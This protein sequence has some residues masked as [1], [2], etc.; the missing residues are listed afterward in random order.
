[1]KEQVVENYNAPA[2]LKILAKVISYVFHPLFI[3]TYVY[4]FMTQLFPFEFSGMLEEA[5]LFR[6]IVVFINTAFFP[7]VAIL[8]LWRLKFIDSIFL[9]SKKERIVP[10]IIIMFFYWWV[11]YLSKNFTDQPFALRVFFLGA[12]LTT[13]FAL[14]INNFFKISMHAIGVGCAAAFITIVGLQ[15]T[16]HIGFFIA[17]A[18]LSA[19]VVCTAR[20]LVSDHTNKEVY[21]GL[22]LGVICQVIAAWVTY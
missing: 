17:V 12:F 9:K 3:P 8:L 5:Y 11:W 10:Y 19:G 4:F 2:V 6:T 16:F 7:G 22:L 20:F 1:M 13:P 18:T 21:A 14:I 15:S